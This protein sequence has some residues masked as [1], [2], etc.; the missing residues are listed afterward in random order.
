MTKASII[1]SL[2]AISIVSMDLALSIVLNKKRHLGWT[3]WFIVFLSSL[4]GL[5]ILFN[6]DLLSSVFWSGKAQFVMRLIWQ[7]F[8]IIDSSFLCVFSVFFCSWLIANPLSWVIKLFAILLGVLYALSSVFGEIFSNTL[9]YTLRY[10][11]ASL[12]LFYIVLIMLINFR[13]I[14]NKRV[15]V[16][17]L[18]LMIIAFSTLPLMASAMVFPF[19]SQLT[20]SILGLAFFIAF[21][22]FLFIAVTTEGKR[23]MTDDAKNEA[24][25]KKYGITSRELEVIKL[26]KKGQTNKEI[27]SFLNISVNTVN[28]HI[29]NIFSKTKT[30][31]RIDLLNLLEEANW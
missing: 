3:R 11:S 20:L 29:A 15:K 25:I 9:C 17:C 28:N 18:T 23:E 2:F 14:E 24:C 13:R 22:V 30:R 8:F 5:S 6:L 26:I 19:L 12:V 16:V 4:L 31:S 21:L 7:I 1:I 10:L 27:A